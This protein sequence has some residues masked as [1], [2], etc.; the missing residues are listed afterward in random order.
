[1]SRIIV[2]AAAFVISIGA[3]IPTF[4]QAR[5][6]ASP[7]PTRPA[8]PQPTPVAAPRPAAAQTSP[9]AMPAN[10]P[11]SKIALVDT[12]VFGDEKVGIRRYVNAVNSVEK[13]FE[14]KTLE[15]RNLQNQLKVIADDI[16]KLSNNTVVSPESV[17]AKQEEGERL[18]RDLKYKKEQADADFQ[19][20]YNDVVGP[21][22]NDI[23]NALIQYASQNGLTMIFDISKLAPAVLTVNPAMDVT[24]AFIADYNSKHP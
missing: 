12:T 16:A 2:I 9:I 5:P 20:R 1:M 23:G 24:Q 6:A 18:Q 7:T 8:A 4:A 3:S 15:L 10:V 17:R 19:K 21:I 22:S 13:I 14:P 11:A